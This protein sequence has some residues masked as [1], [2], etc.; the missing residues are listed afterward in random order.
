MIDIKRTKR[1]I[2]TKKEV[3]II[4]DCYSLKYFII[5]FNFKNI[6]TQVFY[7]L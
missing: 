2:R 4:D 7:Y 6:Y 5:T 3:N 1:N